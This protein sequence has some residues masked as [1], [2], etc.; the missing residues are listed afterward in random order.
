MKNLK[1]Y[2]DY[3]KYN[4]NISYFENILGISLPN[5]YREFAGNYSGGILYKNKYYYKDISGRNTCNRIIILYGLHQVKKQIIDDDFYNYLI[6]GESSNITTSKTNDS[7]FLEYIT[8][9][10]VDGS[11]CIY[12]ECTNHKISKSFNEF[13][14]NIVYD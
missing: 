6:I 4:F 14:N 13:V 11:I 12:D 3:G 2:Y 7:Y 10:I 5:E 9:N 8:I 1:F